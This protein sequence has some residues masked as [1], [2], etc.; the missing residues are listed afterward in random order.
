M[1]RTL[2]LGYIFQLDLA[3][4]IPDGKIEHQLYQQR[5]RVNNFIK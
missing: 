5:L 1:R 4:P 3:V 2:V